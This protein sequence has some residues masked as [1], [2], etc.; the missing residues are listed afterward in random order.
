MVYQ[1]LLHE[2]ALR[3]SSRTMDCLFACSCNRDPHVSGLLKGGYRGD[4]IW[5]Y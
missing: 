1:E 2:K 4:Y 5:E 3:D